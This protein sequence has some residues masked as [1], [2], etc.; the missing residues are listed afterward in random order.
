[1]QKTSIFSFNKNI[2]EIEDKKSRKLFI[3]YSNMNWESRRD[4][5]YLGTLYCFQP[6]DKLYELEIFAENQEEYHKY[7]KYYASDIEI[8]DLSLNSISSRYIKHIDINTLE[9][10]ELNITI[11][12]PYMEEKEFN[13]KI[14][15]GLINGKN[16]KQQVLKI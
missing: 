6:T 5:F 15:N 1:M 9:N 11:K 13:V 4:E 3:G 2:I 14:K 7:D 8:K 16:L 10:F 12:P